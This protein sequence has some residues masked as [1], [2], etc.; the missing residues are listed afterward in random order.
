MALLIQDLPEPSPATPEAVRRDAAIRLGLDPAQIA[1]IDTVRRALDARPRTPVWRL[2][3]KVTL[4]D[5]AQ[6][7]AVLARR[8]R[9]TRAF[10]DRDELRRTG[11]LSDTPADLSPADPAL[12]R[13]RPPADRPVIVIGAGP[14]GLF[15]ALRLAEAGA[16]VLLLDRGGPVEDRVPAVNR[17]WRGGPLDP[18]NNLLFGEGGAGT[19]SDGKIYTRRRDGELGWIF[20]LLVEAGADPSVLTESYPHLGTDKVRAILPA[21]RD[22]LRRAGAEIRYHCRAAALRVEGPPGARR[23]AGV[24][25]ADGTDLPAAAV[26]A[27]PGHSARD[28][29]RMMLDAGAGADLRP[30]AV[31]ARIEHPQALIDQAR[32]PAGRGDL[33]PASYRLAHSPPRGRPGWTFCMCPGGMVVPAMHEPQTVVVNGMSFAARRAAWANSAVIVQAVPGDYPGSDALAGFRFQQ[34]I[35]R[36]AFQETGSYAAPAQRVPDF[37][38]DAPS[39]DL[40]RSSYPMGIS[41]IPLARVLPPSIIAGMKEAILSFEK[42]IPG[43]SKE[44]VLIAPES[45]TTAPLRFRRDAQQ[46]SDLAG[47]FPTGEGAGYAGGIISAALDGFRAAQG[48]LALRAG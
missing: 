44:G 19:F 22:R 39:T 18:E 36:R 48:V 26:I 9:G 11:Q 4:A 2:N 33:P 47:L 12:A 43:F 40:P 14:A 5:P 15:A 31:G 41:P 24:V 20:R 21:L 30:I 34:E 45:R 38:A 6:E 46:Q 13:P 17:F 32:Y 16:P 1:Q 25:L 42:D 27:A 23:C 8:P 29:L 3:L 10:T 28:T 7:P 35:E 37:L